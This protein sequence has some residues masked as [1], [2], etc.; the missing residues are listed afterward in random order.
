MIEDVLAAG[1]IFNDDA[2][3]TS[4][5]GSF[6][7]ELSQA[8]SFTANDGSAAVT[9]TWNLGDTVIDT[10]DPLVI[11]YTARVADVVDNYDGEA[12]GNTATLTYDNVDGDE[13]TDSDT[14]GLAVVEPWIETSKDVS[15]TAGVEAGDTLT[16]TITLTNDG[17]AT[18][19][20]VNFSDTLAQGTT[21]GA[22]QTARIDGTDTSLGTATANGDGSVITFSDDAS[23]SRSGPGPGPHLHGRRDQRCRR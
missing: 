9:I 15:P 21:F 16:Y 1:L 3:I 4:A 13:V 5:S 8:P 19:Y 11:T 14:D 10:D 6:S 20:E 7:T 12:L 2:V 17:N 23:G 18:A 22:I